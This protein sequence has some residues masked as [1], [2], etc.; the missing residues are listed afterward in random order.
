MHAN[1]NRPQKFSFH[2]RKSRIWQA[3]I[4]FL[5]VIG[6]CS[7]KQLCLPIDRC[8]FHDKLIDLNHIFNI[9]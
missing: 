9:T 4:V 8:L 5:L 6:D 1:E 7:S 2:L 3:C